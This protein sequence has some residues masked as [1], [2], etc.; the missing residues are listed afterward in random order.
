[1]LAVHAA[2]VEPLTAAPVDRGDE[3]GALRAGRANTRTAPATPPAA[4]PDLPAAG[5]PVERHTAGSTG[6]TR[7][8]APRSRQGGHT[9]RSWS[10]PAPPSGRAAVAVAYALAQVGKPYRWGA[11]GPGAYDCSGLVVA[12][13]RAAGK[14]LPHQSAQIAHADGVVPVP[15]GQWLPGDVIEMPH[16]VA[17]YLGGGMMV[18]SPHT[19]ASVR[20][21][22]TRGGY[23]VRIL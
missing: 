8:P 3:L 6:T 9:P 4:T 13:Y 16:H 2:R 12:A 21:V 19:G 11:A 20:V 15:A 7:K 5:G 18:E 23:A 14:S 1:M 22:P 10:L 17:I